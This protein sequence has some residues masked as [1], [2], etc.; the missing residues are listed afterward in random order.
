M[1]INNVD[2]S[3]LP[4]DVRKQFKQLQVMYAEKKIRNKAIQDGLAGI[5]RLDAD[6]ANGVIYSPS[7]EDSGINYTNIYD[8]MRKTADTLSIARKMPWLAGFIAM[9]SD[10][11]IHNFEVEPTDEIV[12]R[13]L[14]SIVAT[15]L[16]I[17]SSVM[18]KR[19]TAWWD[20][21]IMA[22]TGF[23]LTSRGRINES[24]H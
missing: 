20:Y 11:D 14:S 16:L 22:G 10:D 12:V 21:H 2:V 1:E 19:D 3:K 5:K 13:V 6:K 15:R 24:L 9:V 4:A 18:Y 23:C 17:E 7:L 8:K